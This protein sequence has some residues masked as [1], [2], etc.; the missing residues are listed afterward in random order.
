VTKEVATSDEYTRH[1]GQNDD[2][3]EDT[4]KDAPAA[5]LQLPIW[6]NSAPVSER[7]AAG[8]ALCCRAIQM[9]VMD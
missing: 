4:Q 3:D 8:A 7:L 2:E 5:G 9:W 6:W 1:L